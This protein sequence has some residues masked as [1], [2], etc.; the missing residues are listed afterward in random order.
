MILCGEFAERCYSR[1]DG[2]E[3]GFEQRYRQLE[4]DGDDTSGAVDTISTSQEVFEK[5]M[6]E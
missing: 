6:E 3:V 5:K 1:E 4:Q 2:G